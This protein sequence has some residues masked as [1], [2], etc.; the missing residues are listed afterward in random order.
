MPSFLIKVK[1]EIP[2]CIIDNLNL[3]WLVSVFYSDLSVIQICLLFRSTCQSDPDSSNFVRQTAQ[4]IC[5]AFD[6]FPIRTFYHSTI[7]PSLSLFF[8]SSPMFSSLRLLLTWLS[9]DNL[10]SHHNQA[11][12]RPYKCF[13]N[14]TLLLHVQKILCKNIKIPT[15]KKIHLLDTKV[16]IN[17]SLRHLIYEKLK[18]DQNQ[19]TSFG[20]SLI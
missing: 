4:R 16:S 17:L 19:G 20:I 18:T 11:S 1:I 2:G 9:I 3:T 5:R 12:F 6:L 8:L 14:L 7:L 15:L 13:S 10:C